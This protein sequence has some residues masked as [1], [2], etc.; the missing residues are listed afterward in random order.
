M[1]FEPV[2]MNNIGSKEK[3]IEVKQDFEFWQDE[4]NVSKL[5]RILT[6]GMPQNAAKKNSGNPLEL[7]HNIWNKLV[8]AVESQGGCIKAARRVV[9]ILATKQ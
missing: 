2:I 5:D 1:D 4:W 3:V 8:E 7:D 9:L 6:E